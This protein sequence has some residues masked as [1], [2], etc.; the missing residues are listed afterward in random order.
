MQ[1]FFNER[2]IF[3]VNRGSALAVI[4][5]QVVLMDNSSLV[6]NG[7]T[8]S[9]GGALSLLGVA[10]FVIGKNTELLF[11]N[12]TA[13][14]FGGAIYNS[15]IGREDFRSSDKCFLQYIDPF[16]HPQEWQTYIK[17][18]N[19]SAGKL[20]NSIYSTTILPCSWTDDLNT[21]I[22]IIRNI[23]CWNE[24][25]WIYENST[26]S[27]EIYTNPLSISTDYH[28]S[29]IYPGY[30]F[31]L[32]VTAWDDLNH[33][34]TKETIFTAVTSDVSTAQVDPEYAYIAD[35]YLSVS[36]KENQNLTLELDVAGFRDWHLE[37]S[38]AMQ[39]C[40][41]GFKP[42]DNLTTSEITCECLGDDV[43]YTYRRNLYCDKPN[44]KSKIRNGYWIGYIPNID[45]NSLL[46][47]ATSLPYR[48]SIGYFS[49]L[50]QS[51]EELDSEQCLPFYR[52][53]PLC[54]E[55]ISNYSTAINS[56][57]FECTLCDNS[58]NK[59]GN[60]FLYIFLT[61]LPYLVMI[62]VIIYFDLSLMS[63]PE[64]GFILHAQLVGAGVLELT[65]NSGSYIKDSYILNGLQKSY[66]I[67]YGI[68]NLNSWA[69]VM[70]PFCVGEGFS[71]L[72][73]LLLDYV[74]AVFLL[75]VIIIALITQCIYDRK[76]KRESKLKKTLSKYK[77]WS[78]VNPFI[79]F[80]YLSYTK[81]T[82]Q[83]KFCGIHTKKCVNWLSE[84]SRSLLCALYTTTVVW[85]SHTAFNVNYT[86][87]LMLK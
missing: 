22:N 64:A 65:K 24:S 68:F 6:F 84:L 63:G 49:P 12:N 87:K 58:I 38:V 37:L 41:P 67:V 61:Y 75:L 42:A 5:T 23:F 20:G 72:D 86:F 26:C 46:M 71:A 69:L 82:L 83:I 77:R 51:Y 30:P 76:I 1:A 13:S 33:N 81:F 40:P 78:P 74:A 53:G 27:D 31:H 34:V 59:V 50:P 43:Q 7:N 4:G 32:N 29:V 45:S 80:L 28:T 54:G 70:P 3:E 36:G 14:L 35:G 48:V 79:A 62:S 47:G 60:A 39:K 56:Y 11:T 25:N 16:S 15:Y 52:T 17:F 73:V 21:D 9:R 18:V 44:L 55:C 57:N 10:S 2:N 8:G 66:R 85:I 19:N